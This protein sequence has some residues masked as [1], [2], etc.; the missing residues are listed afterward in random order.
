[1]TSIMFWFAMLLMGALRRLLSERMLHPEGLQ[2]Q[3]MG[4]L[5]DLVRAIFRVWLH[6]HG[7]H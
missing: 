7:K 3:H 1:M 2:Q 5:K 6:C 4:T